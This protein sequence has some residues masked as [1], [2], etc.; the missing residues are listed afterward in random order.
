MKIQR[1]DEH[2]DVL[3]EEI[4][5]YVRQEPYD[6][7]FERDAE[8]PGCWAA[9]AVERE[10]PPV[11]RLGVIIGDVVHNLRSAL[12]QLVCQLILDGRD[13]KGL[14]TNPRTACSGTGFP[15]YTDESEF[16]TKGI[17]KIKGVRQDLWFKFEALQPF[18]A[19]QHPLAVLNK[20]SNDDKHRAPAVVAFQAESI[21][22]VTPKDF[23]SLGMRGP[24]H[25]EDGTVLLRF[26][27]NPEIARPNDW[28]PDDELKP[29]LS[30]DVAFAKGPPAY[31][32]RV[33]ETLHHLR[34]HV[35]L[36]LEDF[37]PLLP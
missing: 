24:Q 12:D 10:A 21:M 27:L 1:A 20:L 28:T 13:H 4:G 9:V 8:F 37:R 23:S 22:L 26:G 18:D 32:G 7:R 14:T 15:I 31:G 30:L 6:V 19:G 33:M 17:S 25:L 16:R 29:D 34:H 2:L 35:V 5:T 11:L 36:I 3:R